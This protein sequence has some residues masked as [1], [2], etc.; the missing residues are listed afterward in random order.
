MAGGPIRDGGLDLG[1]ATIPVLLA[2][3]VEIIRSLW[4]GEVGLDILAA[5][6]MAAALIFGEY[7]AAVVVAMMYSGGTFLERLAE[8]RA[9]RETCDLLGRVPRTAIRHQNDALVEVVLDAVM[10]DDR[11]LMRQ[12]DVAPVDGTVAMGFAVMDQSALAGETMPVCWGRA[13][14]L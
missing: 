13:R 7:L 3:L 8:G 14:R 6:S 10:P 9:R 12:G 4:R 5:P 1:A 2:L 11:L